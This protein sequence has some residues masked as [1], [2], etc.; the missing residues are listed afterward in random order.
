MLSFVNYRVNV[1]LYLVT[2]VCVTVYYAI[3]PYLGDTQEWGLHILINNIDLN[4]KY[5]LH[6][7]VMRD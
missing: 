1:W 4:L 7:G 2:C 6:T 5:Y 3:V